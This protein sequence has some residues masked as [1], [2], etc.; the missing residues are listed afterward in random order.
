[1]AHS[2]AHDPLQPHAH[3]PNPAPPSVDPSFAFVFP[4][5]AETTVTVAQLERLPLTSVPNCYIVSTGHGA[6]G[7]F[8]FGGVKL[9]DLI[10]SRL[11]PQTGWSQVE[12]ISADGFGNRVFKA[13]LL[14]PNPAGPVLLAYLLD[15]QQMTREQ[16]LV[17]MV[18]PAEKDDALRQVKWVG[19]VAVRP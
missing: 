16:G 14:N 8:T 13:E 19:R 12:V 11:S 1:M 15:G 5:G 4:D 18:V 2:H 9:L 10:K 6:S 7:P 3:N 17:R